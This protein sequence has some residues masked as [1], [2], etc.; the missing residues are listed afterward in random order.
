ML[1][2]EFVNSAI[3]FIMQDLMDKEHFLMRDY[4]EVLKEM[5]AKN[6]LHSSITIDRM[7]ELCAE[8]IRSRMQDSWRILAVLIKEAGISYSDDLE[9]QL[10]KILEDILVGEF[11]DIKQLFDRTASM[12]HPAEPAIKQFEARLGQV[13]FSEF[14]LLRREVADFVSRLKSGFAEVQAEAAPSVEDEHADKWLGRGMDAQDDLKNVLFSLEFGINT[15]EEPL[16]KAELIELVRAIRSELDR[17]EAND[18][19]LQGLLTTVGT[20]IRN[21]PSLFEVYEDLREILAEMGTVLP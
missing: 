17:P 15:T 14:N 18:S 4:E 6:M 11:A 1:D 9:A 12:A 10:V 20:S 16:P 21:V 3:N 19:K 7:N 5:E 8:S 2:A 13:S